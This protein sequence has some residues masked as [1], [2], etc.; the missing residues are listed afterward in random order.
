MLGLSEF[1]VSSSIK[2][3]TLAISAVTFTAMWI[4][5]VVDCYKVEIM[6][7]I[8]LILI[9][10]IAAAIISVITGGL[11]VPSGIGIITA[12]FYSGSASAAQEKECSLSCSKANNFHFANALPEPITDVEQF[13]IEEGFGPPTSPYDVCACEDG[14]LVIYQVKLCG[15]INWNNFPHITGYRWK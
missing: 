14:S 9:A 13:K 2:M 12:L 3:A 4:G 8:A 5:N 6:S 10:I 1:L 11:G 15:K 7:L